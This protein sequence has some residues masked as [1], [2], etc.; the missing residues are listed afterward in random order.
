MRAQSELFLASGARLRVA[1]DYDE[2]TLPLGDGDGD[3]HSWHEYE[4]AMPGTIGLPVWVRCSSVE[5]V[6]A[7]D[8]LGE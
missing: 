4:L 5:A 1:E 6:A 8:D 7:V 2:A 3:E